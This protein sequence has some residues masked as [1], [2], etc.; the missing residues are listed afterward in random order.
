MCDFLAGFQLPELTTAECLANLF[1]AQIFLRLD[2]HDAESLLAGARCSPAPVDVTL[3]RNVKKSN[4]SLAD[5]QYRMIPFEL[6]LFI[7]Q[8]PTVGKHN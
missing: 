2:E 5:G 3:Q 6:R 7:R 8:F 4:S 1:V